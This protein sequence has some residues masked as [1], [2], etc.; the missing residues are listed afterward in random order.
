MKQCAE[1]S[2]ST[3]RRL[4][5]KTASNL[6][7]VWRWSFV[8]MFIVEPLQTPPTQ[9]FLYSSPMQASSSTVPARLRVW[10][11]GRGWRACWW[12]RG[13]WSTSR[14]RCGAA[15][16]SVPPQRREK[17]EQGDGGMYSGRQGDRGAFGATRPCRG[18]RG[19]LETRFPIQNHFVVS[20]PLSAAGLQLLCPM[21]PPPL[22]LLQASSCYPRP[23]PRPSYLCCRRRCWPRSSVNGWWRLTLR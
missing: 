8:F 20:T 19:T 9:D 21:P 4:G 7:G 18:A 5:A 1:L 12:A 15:A 13:C 17:V 16:A 23:S 14:S 10:S 3:S 6:H 2:C 22:S 11:G